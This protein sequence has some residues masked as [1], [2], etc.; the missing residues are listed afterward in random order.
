MAAVR[1]RIGYAVDKNLFYSSIGLLSGIFSG[2]VGFD[3]G[4][5]DYS[6]VAVDDERRNGIS[7][8]IGFARM[9]AD[10]LALELEGE[11][12]TFETGYSHMYRTS[13]GSQQVGEIGFGLSRTVV[14]AGL[15]YRF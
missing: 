8:G 7:F 12:Q 11:Y 10:N 9:L 6:D 15:T 2:I 3:G 5:E 14:R 4:G 1:G 13:D